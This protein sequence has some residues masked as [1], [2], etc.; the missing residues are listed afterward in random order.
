MTPPNSTAHSALAAAARGWY[1]FPVARGDKVPLRGWKWTEHHTTDPDVIQRFWSRAPYN[2][3]IATGPSGLVVIDLDTPKDGETAPPPWDLPGVREGADVLALLCEQAGQP[4]PFETFQVRTRRGG[5]HLYFR[6]P[7]GLRLGNTS[8]RLGWLIDTRADGGYVVG[9]GSLV[10][11]PD[12]TGIYD[13]LHASDVAPLPEWLTVRLT[14][15]V[16]DT[17]RVRL[18]AHEVLASLG[19][20]STGYALVALRSEVQRVLDAAPGTRN[21]TLNAAAFALGQLSA[22]RLLPHQLIEDALHAAANAIGLSPREATATIRSGLNA[23]AR[24]PRR[25]NA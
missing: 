14:P 6:A 17:V 3:G 12:G 2:V 11:L 18:P 10:D 21:H 22:S 20:R 7:E 19:D 4:L 5:T 9:P 23:G 25:G 15:A 13:V 8:K 16:P 1:V 24:Q